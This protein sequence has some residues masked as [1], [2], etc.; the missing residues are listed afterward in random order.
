MLV[1]KKNELMSNILFTVHQHG[2]DDATWKPPIAYEI[3]PFRARVQERE[4]VEPVL[5]GLPPSS[6]ISLHGRNEM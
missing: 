3:K 1:D 2:G 6:P 4:K 5:R